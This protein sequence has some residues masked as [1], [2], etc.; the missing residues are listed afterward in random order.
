MDAIRV[1][2]LEERGD[3]NVVHDNDFSIENNNE[4]I[5]VIQ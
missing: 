3:D 4:M 1:T 2:D 5:D